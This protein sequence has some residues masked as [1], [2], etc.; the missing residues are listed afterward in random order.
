MF[1]GVRALATA[2]QTRGAPNL[3]WPEVR[4][5]YVKSSTDSWVLEQKCS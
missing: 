5:A 3:T 4:V 1:E 2:A